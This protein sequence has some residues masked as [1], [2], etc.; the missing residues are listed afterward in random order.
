MPAPE[1]EDLENMLQVITSFQGDNNGSSEM[2]EKETDMI[3]MMLNEE[4]QK[5]S[6]M[7]SSFNTQNPMETNR[8][9]IPQS[10]LT[11]P[12]MREVYMLLYNQ[13]AY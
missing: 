4:L 1:P 9:N 12:D 3:I 10:Q 13:K 11:N 2:S 5:R 8:S 7:A 6:E